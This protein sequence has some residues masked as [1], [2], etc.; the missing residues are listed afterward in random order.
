LH[1]R[2]LTGYHNLIRLSS[3]GHTEG[4]YRKP[5]IDKEVLAE[6]AEGIVCLSACMSGELAL[7][8]RNGWYDR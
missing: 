5:R 8:L 7:Y 6:H 3:I 4:F 2:D 1:A